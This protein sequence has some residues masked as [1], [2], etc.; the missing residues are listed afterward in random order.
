ML[1]CIITAPMKGGVSMFADGHKIAM[2]MKAEYPLYYQMLC[3]VPID[4]IGVGTDYYGNFYK[5]GSHTT[6]R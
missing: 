1:H 6:I 5:M 3:Q 4:F 2:Q